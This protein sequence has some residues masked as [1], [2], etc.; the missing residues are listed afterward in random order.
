V[1]RASNAAGPPE[2]LACIAA[3]DGTA[4][5]LAGGLG[6]GEGLGDGLGEGLGEG[7]GD[8]VATADGDGLLREA[9]A[10]F[11]QPATASITMTAASL[12][13][14]GNRN[15]A[16]RADVT[17][18]V[19]EVTA[20]TI[21]PPVSGLNGRRVYGMKA[22]LMVV[23]VLLSACIDTPTPFTA[24]VNASASQSATVGGRAQLVVSITNTGPPIPHIGL[25]F[26]S[27]DKW[28]ERHTVTD[29][30]ACTINPDYSA[31]DC[32]DLAAGASATF[33]ITGTAS[34]AGTFH[35]ELA[36]RELVRPFNYVNDHPNGA[37]VQAWDETIAP[38]STS[39]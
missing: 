33:S 32:G 26:V 17:A 10:E 31:L 25:T 9:V 23:V 15:A 30:G 24:D 3:Q 18:E 16:S 7:L 28:Y 13:P 2:Q 6:L 35:Y 38:S 1:T 21:S 4:T 12:I 14:T 39:P 22:A 8:A 34:Q 20:S 27:A 29:P 5:G 11:E 37:D 36:L 19:V